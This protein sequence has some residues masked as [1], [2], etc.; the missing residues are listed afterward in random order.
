MPRGRRRA[1][2]TTKRA[3]IGGA[4][5]AGVLGL[6]AGPAGASWG[7]EPPATIAPFPPAATTVDLSAGVFQGFAGI[8]ANEVDW[9]TFVAPRT[10]VHLIQTSTTTNPP[11]TVLGV[12]SSAGNRLAYSDDYAP[13][14]RDS[15]VEV[16]LTSGVRYYFGITNYI[17]TGQGSYEYLVRAP[18]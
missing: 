18:K 14:D 1:L 9:Y 15:R 3:A 5:A 4:L 2:R 7:A 12:Y 17:N 13:P 10:G 11:D 16:S 6:S 8:E